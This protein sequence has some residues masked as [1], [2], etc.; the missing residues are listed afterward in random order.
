MPFIGE[1]WIDTKWSKNT[2]Q[3]QNWGF[4]LFYESGCWA[5]EAPAM[6]LRFH[7]TTLV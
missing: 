5:A 7:S 6:Q 4:V 2:E 1:R 3:N